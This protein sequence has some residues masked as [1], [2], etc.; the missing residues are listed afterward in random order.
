M[1]SPPSA[2]P[3]TLRLIFWVSLAL[4][5][6]FAADAAWRILND[7]GRR[8]VEDWMSPRH[9]MAVFH[10]PETDLGRILGFPPGAPPFA[11]I[12]DL[13]QAQGRSVAEV[14]AEIQAAADAHAGDGP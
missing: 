12:R 3:L 13:A 4:G 9:V 1:T 14:M 8:P 11:S 2:T 6:A 7:D 10:V 5:L